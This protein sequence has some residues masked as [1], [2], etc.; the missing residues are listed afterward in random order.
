MRGVTVTR[1]RTQLVHLPMAEPVDGGTIMLRTTDCVLVFLE[2]NAGLVGEG[3]IHVLN[4]R[5]LEV[6]HEVVKSLEPIVLGLDV[7]MAGSLSLK[8]KADLA[9]LGHAS[10]AAMGTAGI[11]MA[12]W[13]L[14]AKAAGLNVSAMLGVCR[15]A[16]PVYHSGGLWLSRS[17][18]ELQREAADFVRGGYRAVKVRVGKFD[19]NA[20]VA[21]VRAVREAIGPDVALMADANQQLTVR[22]AIRLGRALEEF[23]LTWFEEPVFHADHEGE[24]AVAAALDT[25]IASG[26]SV[27]TSDAIA[28]M[29]QRRSADVLMPDLQRMGGPSEFVKAA[30]IA[31]AYNKPVSPHLFP[32]MS[33][34]LAA[35]VPNATYIEYMPWLEPIYAERLEMDG[36]G[37]AVVPTAPGWGFRFDPAAITKYAA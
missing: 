7:G 28:H 4:N 21:R 15:K 13:D 24:A 20:D 25:P 14:R 30:R 34:S 1:L 2:S 37:R 8:A 19:C 16:V 23:D 18:D 36:E 10:S 31:D 32:E 26:E 11:E 35:S 22:D 6:L 29:L 27:Y 33:L 5:R 12:L 17:I 3:L 9:F